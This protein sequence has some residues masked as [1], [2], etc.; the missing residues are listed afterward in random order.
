MTDDD[1]DPL[2]DLNASPLNPLP[3]A[4]WLLLLAVIGIEA[5][6]SA[7]S[8]GLIGGQQA[9]GWRIETIQN[10]AFSSGIQDWMLQNWRFPVRHLTRFSSNARRSMCCVSPISPPACRP[11][12]CS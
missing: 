6:L 3:G 12:S 2:A 4:V 9:V 1:H 7:G 11:I 8:A 5:V 10:Y